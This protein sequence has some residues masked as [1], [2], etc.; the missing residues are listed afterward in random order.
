MSAGY[1]KDLRGKALFLVS[2]NGSVAKSA[3]ILCIGSVSIYRW[4]KLKK[5][6][7]SVAAK[8]NWQ[9]GH[10]H[11]ITDLNELARFAEENSGLTAIE[12][13]KK[14]GNITP[15]TIRKWL[16]R[17]GYSCK[18]KHL[19]TKNGIQKSVPLTWHT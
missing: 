11:K 10:S 12:M 14:W 5:E 4:I 16:H 19:D 2:K 9:N 8:K 1:S 7:G 18:K 13:A 3:E 17:I 15:K 6:T